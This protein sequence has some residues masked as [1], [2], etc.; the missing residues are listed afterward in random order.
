MLIWGFD[1]NFTNYTELL[2]RG[3]LVLL[4]A[5]AQHRL[6]AAAG[7]TMMLNHININ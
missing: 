3:V 5:L 1:Y 6:G 7:T 2:L 4:E